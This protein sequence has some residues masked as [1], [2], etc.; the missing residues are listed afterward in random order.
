MDPILDDKAA[1]QLQ[2]DLRG[3][4]RSAHES[5]RPILT[6]LNADTTWLVSLPYPSHESPP[7]GR[8]RYNLLIDP[9]LQ[10]SQEDLSAWFSKQWHGVQSSV[11]TISELEELL[12][13]AESLERENANSSSGTNV[14]AEPSLSYIDAVAVSHEFTDHCHRDTLTELNPS[15]PVFATKKAASLIRSWKHFHT[16]IEMSTFSKGM[17]WRTTSRPPLPNWI[18]ISRLMTSFDLGSL[19]SAVLVCFGE[20]QSPDPTA[21]TLI[22]TPHGIEASTA[23]VLNTASPR[24]NNLAFL[25]GLQDVSLGWAQQLNLGAVNA[26]K[27]Q[28]VLQAKYWIGTHDEDKPASGLVARFLKIKKGSVQEALSQLSAAENE[29]TNGASD[30]ATDITCVELRNGESLLL[31]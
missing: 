14:P 10:G 5:K 2:N 21:E 25:H 19:H 20:P 24:L 31:E 7:P 4:L 13:E 29:K 27:A 28:K 15:V 9:W 26:V 22:Y 23:S 1:S 16:V 11:Q 6:H 3:S 18:G 17:D 8:L 30:W 12:R